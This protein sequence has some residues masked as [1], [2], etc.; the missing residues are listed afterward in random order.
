MP[1]ILALFASNWVRWLHRLGAPGLLLLGLADNSP[2]PLPGSMD[3]LTIW[4]AA[5]QPHLWPLYA[6]LATV[7][8]VVGG[9][10]TY[11]LARKGGKEALEGKLSKKTAARVNS[12]FERWGFFAV[13]VPALLP[14][15]FPIVPF[16]VAAGALQFPQRKFLGAIGI[17]RAIR[18]SVTASLGAIYGRHILRFFARYY[19]PALWTL[20]ALS[21]V[22]GLLTLLKYYQHRSTAKAGS[23]RVAQKTA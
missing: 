11:G 10:V 14:P 17:G 12:S 13:A 18:F 5:R 1:A 15:P 23:G 22:G 21:V 19:K 3:I 7:G 8:S 16:L 2:I 6:A 4:L 9:Y 20:I